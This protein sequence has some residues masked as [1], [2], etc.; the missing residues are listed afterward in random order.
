MIFE[1]YWTTMQAAKVTFKDIPHKLAQN[2]FT[3]N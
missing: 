1:K 2:D 3:K